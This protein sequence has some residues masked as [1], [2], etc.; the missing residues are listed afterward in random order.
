[1]RKVTLKAFGG[2]KNE[3][4]VTDDTQTQPVPIANTPLQESEL[5]TCWY[6]IINRMPQ[7]EKAM[8]TRMRD[9]RPGIEG[10]S[11]IVVTVYN[12]QVANEMKRML[13][14]METYIR[15]RLNNSEAHIDVRVAEAEKAQKIF[16][17]PER[18]RNMMQQNHAVARLVK[19]MNLRIE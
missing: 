8:A 3:V 18:L 1:M 6:E 11:T 7:E 4:K 19:E 5:H 2:K 15:K 16:S 9:M 17:K 10:T 12:N 14:R 13:P